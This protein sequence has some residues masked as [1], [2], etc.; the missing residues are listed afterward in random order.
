LPFVAVGAAA[1]CMWR[2]RFADALVALALISCVFEVAAV[3]NTYWTDALTHDAPYVLA[4][5]V[6]IALAVV[7]LRSAALR[8]AIAVAVL[9]AMCSW[10]SGLAG[11]R[12][13]AYL[14]DR[15]GADGV[16]AGAFA[17]FGATTSERVVVVQLPAG[18][19]SLLRSDVDIYDAQPEQACARARMLHAQLL[20]GL[21]GGAAALACGRVI[22]RDRSSALVQTV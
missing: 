14:A 5:T 15:Y 4:C 13:A 20:V 11:A 10:S 7:V 18:A 1:L 17:A 22:F 12:P 2:L 6:V 9:L 16:P 8:S 19:A 3:W 21:P